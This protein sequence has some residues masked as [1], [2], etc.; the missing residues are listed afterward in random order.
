MLKVRKSNLFF[1]QYVVSFLEETRGE[2]FVFVANATE[3]KIEVEIDVTTTVMKANTTGKKFGFGL[4]PLAGEAHFEV[5][6]GD[7]SDASHVTE[8]AKQPPHDV[9]PHSLWRVSVP[10]SKMKPR[11]LSMQ[12]RN[13]IQVVVH[14]QNEAE[15]IK[16]GSYVVGI[17]FFTAMFFGGEGQ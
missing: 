12:I 3:D 5:D 6:L 16:I 13:S 8:T 10:P 1:L 2:K 14:R 15:K 4:A 11:G 17:Y 9:G 7:A